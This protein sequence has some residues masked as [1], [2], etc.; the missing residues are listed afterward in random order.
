MGP[1]CD[2]LRGY[3]GRGATDHRWHGRGSHGAAK[4]DWPQFGAALAVV[5]AGIVAAFAGPSGAWAVAGIGLF[6]GVAGHAAVTAWL[7]RATSRI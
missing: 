7:E 4:A 5:T 1:V 3:P 2:R 6:I